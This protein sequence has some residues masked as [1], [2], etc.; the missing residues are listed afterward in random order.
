MKP[1]AFNKNP[2][3]LPPSAHKNKQSYNKYKQQ[4]HANDEV[5]QKKPEEPIFSRT[6]ANSNDHIDDFEEVAE[7]QKKVK[8]FVKQKK[9]T[10]A[11]E[12]KVSG[13]ETKEAQPVPAVA[14]EKPVAREPIT[15]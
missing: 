15:R 12:K 9:P 5:G 1:I 13:E 10:D 6:Q 3:F 8:V 7:K 4:Q 14:T 11:T 2:Y